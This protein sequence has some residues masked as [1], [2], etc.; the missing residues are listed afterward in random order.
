MVQAR[1]DDEQ[2]YRL[3]ASGRHARPDMEGPPNLNSSTLVF[4]PDVGALEIQLSRLAREISQGSTPLAAILKAA[5]AARAIS[6][7]RSGD[8]VSAQWAFAAALLADAVAC[9]ARVWL[10]DSR[11]CISWPDWRDP[12]NRETLRVALGR[13]RLEV[14]RLPA[15]ADV[16]TFLPPDLTPKGLV[17]LIRRGE[18]ELVDARERLGTTSVMSVYQACRSY[19]QLPNRDREG[20]SRK[21]V[22]LIREDTSTS[23]LAA[24][25]LEVAD[26]PPYSTLRDELLGLLPEAFLAWLRGAEDR[27]AQLQTLA[28]RLRAFRDAL[29][30]PRELRRLDSS[31]IYLKWRELDEKAA[32]RSVDDGQVS[33][34]KQV[35]YLVRLVRGER[36]VTSMLGCGQADP[37]DLQ[38]GLRVL[39]NLLIPRLHVEASICG[40]V[41]PFSSMLVGKLVA[42]FFGDPRISALCTGT[43]GEILLSMFDK[44]KL[45]RLLPNHGAILVTTA[46]LYPHHSAQYERAAIPGSPGTP[47]LPLRK[48]GV[49]SGETASLVSKATYEM[50]VRV[51]ATLRGGPR[52]G[53]AYGAGG[54][55]RQR[56]IE[57]AARGTGLPDAVVHPG[58]PRPIYAAMLVSN[59][60]ETAVLG[61][62][63]HWI[64]ASRIAPSE[65][66]DLAVAQWLARW[67]S[68]ITRRAMVSPSD[69]IQGLRTI[70]AQGTE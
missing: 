19:W 32:G 60:I 70:L 30:C 7:E 67:G 47:P 41:P 34:R 25:I 23:P 17:E 69:P 4:A 48:V 59:P 61:V 36:A 12:S 37:S 29:L 1:P 64:A 63:P 18:F 20:R 13:L 45:P 3:Q 65:Y 62:A 55:K 44:E 56:Q 31:A 42:S 53:T 50:A 22:L 40:A 14:E 49:T 6:D 39:Q 54:S 43:P 28:S 51:L 2:C 46:G 9:G 27:D 5:R 16:L 10:S 57:A 58:I 66:K 38:A 24:G 8:T 52:V 33:N 21:F 35:A 15:T 68:A 11:I 26:G